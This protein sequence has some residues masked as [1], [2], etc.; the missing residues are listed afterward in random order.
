MVAVGSPAPPYS[1]LSRPLV[2]YKGTCPFCRASA[3][4]VARLDREERL[5]LL[6]FDDADAAEFLEPY[7]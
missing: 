2:L 6:P 4:L 1:R 3:R 5:A 7:P